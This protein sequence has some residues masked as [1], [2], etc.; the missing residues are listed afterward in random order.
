MNHEF[1]IFISFKATDGGEVTH[2]V[3]VA[4]NL[5]HSLT[6]SGYRVFFSE[7]TLQH[8]GS[9]DFSKE[10]DSAL[11]D[12]R[13]LIVVSSKLEYINSRWIEYEWKTFNS[14]I[15]SDVKKN[16]QI[17]T[18]TENIDPR[19]LPRILRYVQ[20]YSYNDFDSLISFINAFFDRIS[21]PERKKREEQAALSKKQ[22]RLSANDHNVY[23]FSGNGEIEIFKLRE[24]NSYAIDMKA[25]NYVKSQMNRKKYNVLVLGC[26]YGFIAE[27][28]FGLDDD[29]E[30][31]IC[32]DKSEAVLAKA[33]Q[34]YANY[35][36]MK[37]YQVELQCQSYA[38]K[39]RAILDENGID[40]IDI[41]FA[42]DLF[43]YL[44]CPQIP[45]RCTR[46][47]LR[48][49]GFLICKGCD[50]SKKA[51]YPDPS[52]CLG[53][54]LNSCRLLPGMPNYY[55]GKEMPILLANAGF[56]IKSIM[57]D[58]ISTVNMSFEEKEE[59]FLS[60]FTRRKN[61]ANKILQRDPHTEPHVE[62]LLAEI[63]DFENIFY[64]T[65][66][67]YSDSTLLFIAQK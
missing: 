55:I 15:L 2:D 12:A 11:D 16:A 47:I 6:S 59:L 58:I 65:G 30:N 32:I 53:K 18:F 39:I 5:Y 22:E 13:L 25:I 67:W 1:D 29:I 3:E 24:R 57:T 37:F 28:R 42:A 14:D 27:T 17:I 46:K 61:I 8:G 62:K 36:H 4:S 49:G 26:A 66:F 48:K 41:V 20:N 50:D 60:S 38:E 54:L 7:E 44:N 63:D 33:R 34:L 23:D 19:T 40:E 45:L 10:I 64:N 56:R 35:P 9:A 43:R 31:V 21:I 51:A 52:D